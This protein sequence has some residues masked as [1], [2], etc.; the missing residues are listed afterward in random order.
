MD[1]S[2]RS[3]V[4]VTDVVEANLLAC[5]TPGIAGG[6]FNVGGGRRISVN[7]L[8]SEIRRQT[9]SAGA[10]RYVAARV[11]D[12][13]DSLA[14][15]ERSRQALGYEPRITLERGLEDTVRSFRSQQAVLRTSR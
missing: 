9:G 14:S 6:V 13:R 10:P 3:Y 12:V 8:W 5:H 11:G 2:G 4:G 1:R 7:D 15:L